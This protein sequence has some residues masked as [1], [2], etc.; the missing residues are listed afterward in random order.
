MSVYHGRAGFIQV[1]MVCVPQFGLETDESQNG[2][3]RAN[4]GLCGCFR[5][6]SLHLKTHTT[7]TVVAHVTL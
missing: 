2:G 4:E 7:R 3:H 6:G 5:T 1:H